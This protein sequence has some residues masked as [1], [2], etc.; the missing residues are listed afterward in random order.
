MIVNSSVARG[1]RI[2]SGEKCPMS[3]DKGVNS[4]SLSWHSRETRAETIPH[5][6]EDPHEIFP[7]L[8]PMSDLY[9]SHEDFSKA[10]IRSHQRFTALHSSDEDSRR[11]ALE[12][13]ES[14]QLRISRTRHILSE[15]FFQPKPFDRNR[16]SHPKQIGKAIYGELTVVNDSLLNKRVVLKGV[17]NESTH[18]NYFELTSQLEN[19]Y[20]EFSIIRYLFSKTCPVDPLFIVT[21]YD[22][23]RDEYK[24]YLIQEYCPHGEL[25]SKLKKEGVFREDKA[26]SIAVQL[27]F[28]ILSLHSNFICHRDLSLENVLISEDRSVRVIDF[29][30]AE[31]LLDEH[32][33]PKY[34]TG[35]V[36]KSYYRAPE[37]YFGSYV[38]APIDIFA[39][40][41]MIYI[42][43]TGSPPFGD[44]L[45]TDP[46]FHV[47]SSSPDGLH[48]ALM[49]EEVPMSEDLIDLLSAIF[50]RPPAHRPTPVE[51]LTHRWFTKDPRSGWPIVAHLYPNSEL[52]RRTFYRVNDYLETHGGQ[53][54]R[55]WQYPAS[56]LVDS[57]E[58]GANLARSFSTTWLWKRHRA[59]RV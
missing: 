53:G 10:H 39:L 8:S 46:R 38:G 55:F 48:R 2:I 52:V 41:V 19:P 59:A 13:Q 54:R 42:L 1:N 7:T 21:P 50:F 33:E 30:Q 31:F 44:A 32:K 37:V 58:L 4:P 16:F 17:R 20:Q 40:G 43:V 9:P 6:E 25:F 5:K 14:P 49:E 22:L 45:P 27:L 35:K 18:R 11:T 36:G 3:L 26:R 51:L 15:D 28:A 23:M 34:L 24:T 12:R 57:P 56:C 47:I 29:G